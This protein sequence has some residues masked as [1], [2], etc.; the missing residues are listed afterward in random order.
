LFPHEEFVM[1][2]RLSWLVGLSFFICSYLFADENLKINFDKQKIKI[3]SKIVEVEIAKTPDQHQYGLMNRNS[4]P[5]NN[6]MLFIFENEQTLSFWMKNTFIDLSIA[7]IDK[8]K[9]IV[10]IQEMKATN[11]M[12]VDDLPSYPSAKPALYAL[13]MNRGWFKK[14]KI[15]IGQKFNFVK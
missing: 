6:G 9:Q 8:N 10:D 1:A 3:G 5:E 12:M 15:K 2:L 11:Q 13:E 4:L 7:Y 14:N